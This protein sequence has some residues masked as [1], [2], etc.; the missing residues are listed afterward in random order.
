M[1]DLDRDKFY[2]AELD[3]DEGEYE[4]EPPD[5]AVLANER[6]QAEE[7]IEEVRRSINIDDLYRDDR[8]LTGEEIFGDWLRDFRLRFQVKHLLIAMATLSVVLVL[9]KFG[10]LEHFAAIGFMGLVFAAYAFA[11]WREKQFRDETE[12]RREELYEK[13][14]EARKPYKRAQID[15]VDPDR[16]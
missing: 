9:W 6:R 10:V 13:A 11:E 2:S 5:P 16:P 1:S 14:R 12:R 8:E 3:D 4:L 7:K 15:Q